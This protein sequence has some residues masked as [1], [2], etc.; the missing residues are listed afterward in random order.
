MKKS[1]II[2]LAIL[3]VLGVAVWF[4]MFRKAGRY[5]VMQGVPADAVFVVK[6]PSF[7]SIHERLRRNRIWES[8]KSYPSFEAYHGMLNSADSVCDAYPVLKK[9]LIDRPFAVSCHLLG[10]TD[11]DFLYVCDLGKLNVVQTL[12]GAVGAWL[13]EGDVSLKKRDGLTEVT[14]GGVKLYYCIRENLLLASLSERLVRR[15]ADSCGKNTDPGDVLTGGDLVLNLNHQELDRLIS[16]LSGGPVQ[17]AGDSSVLSTTRL[18]LDLADDALQFKGVTL[19]ERSRFSLLSALN[20]M[21]GAQSGVGNIAGSRTAAYVS[22]CFGSFTEL[23]NVLLENYK[24]NNLKEY[25][26]YEHTV[27]RLNKYL[28]LNVAEVFTS[29]IGNEIAFIKPE[30]DREKRLDNVVVAIRS[31]DIDLAKDQLSY[32]T[33]QI[34]RKTPVRFRAIEYNGHTI[35]YLSLKGFFNMFFGGWFQKLE[36]PYYTFLGDYVVFSNSSATLATMI[37]EYV[38]ENTLSKD[39]KYRNL[40]GKFGSGNSVYGYINSPGTYEYLYH[41]FKPEERAAFAR[42]KGAFES[43]ENVGFALANAGSGFE[44]RIIACHNKNASEEYKVKVINNELED[45]ADRVES[46]YYTP[47]I[48]DSIAVSTREDY[49]YKTQELEFAGLLDNGEPAGVWKVDDTQGHKVGQIAFQDGQ[50]QGEAYFFYPDGEVRARVAYNKGK[51]VSF[52]ELFPDGTLKTE[53][54]YNKGIRHGD[55][56]FYYSTGHLF[57]EGKYRKGRRT[58]TWKYFRVT[59]ETERKVKF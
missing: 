11:Y 42:N 33:E 32:L 37:K 36:R 46:G 6:T 15:A 55:V 51:I 29:W 31:K 59:G 44:T 20:L 56:R 52:R 30:V 24:V 53:V 28:G 13:G 43:F 14:M 27:D 1:L 25:S 38:L 5:E 7:N 45:L 17:G 50:L 12:D 2:T 16:G 8:L 58:G 18:T 3:V 26:E 34:E 21:S 22:L 48:P 19:P 57:G 23:E 39:E 35:N 49:S 4:W 47:V 9:L 54:E 40:M 10:G 41:F